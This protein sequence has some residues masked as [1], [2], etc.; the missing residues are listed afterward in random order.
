MLDTRDITY[1][2]EQVGGCAWYRCRTPG[3]A[4]ADK[5]Y[6]IDLTNALTGERVRASKTIVWQRPSLA[7]SSAAIKL[8]KSLGIH[9]V[10]EIDDDYWSLSDDNPAKPSWTKLDGLP[11]R[12]LTACVQEADRVTVTT[13]GLANVVRVLNPNVFVIPNQLPDDYWPLLERNYSCPPVIGW[14]G[15]STHRGDLNV[16]RDVIATAAKD[17]TVALVGAFSDWVGFHPSVHHCAS[18]PIDEYQKLVAGFD[19]GLAPLA[20]TRFNRSKSDLKVLEYAAVSIPVIASPHYA[21]TPARI[22]K[23]YRDWIRHIKAL[24]DPETRET[25][26]RAMRAWAETRMASLHTE[27]WEAAC[28]LTR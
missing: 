4:L 9:T 22:A 21:N 17:N 11:L 1:V 8:A 6:R 3:S 19:I 25:E 5:G 23:T 26:G 10:V 15:S 14:A 13:K 16:I 2:I 27:E 20:D 28:S 24:Q 7:H 12:T 18:V